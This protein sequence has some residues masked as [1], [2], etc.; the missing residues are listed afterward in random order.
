MVESESTCERREELEEKKSAVTAK[1]SLFAFV[2]I[3]THSGY[4]YLFNSTINS[5]LILKLVLSAHHSMVLLNELINQL[6]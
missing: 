5:L 3:P 2:S 6:P 4:C 1:E